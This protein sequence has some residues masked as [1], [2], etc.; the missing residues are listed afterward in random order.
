MTKP[1]SSSY[2]QGEKKE[3][4]NMQKTNEKVMI[5]DETPKGRKGIKEM[6]DR[7]SEIKDSSGSKPHTLD[8][9][10]A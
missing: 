10:T 9:E 7:M 5:I 1:L 3:E 8:K 6:I 2:W 4:M